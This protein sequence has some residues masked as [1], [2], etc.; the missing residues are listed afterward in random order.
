MK[1]STAA[2]IDQ[3]AHQRRGFERIADAHLAVRMREARDDVVEARAMHDQAARRRAALARRADGAEHDRRHDE[4]E[5]GI[6]GDDDRVV[7]AAFEQH[8]AEAGAHCACDLL[9][10][11]ATIR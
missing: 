4:I 7:A 9:A 10:R 8:L 3:R 2:R 11:R 5:V 1:A 6:V